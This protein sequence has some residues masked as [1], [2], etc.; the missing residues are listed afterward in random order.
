MKPKLFTSIILFLSAYSPLL[1]IFAVKDFN[2]ELNWFNHPIASS[3][4][5]LI[6]VS[7]IFILYTI[8]DEIKV[9]SMAV[10]IKAVNNRS[11]DVIN[12]TIP[13]LFCAFDIDLNQIADII[14]IVIFLIILFILT[15]SSK[16]IFINPILA[17]QGYAFYDVKYEFDSVE[18]DSVFISKEDLKKDEVYYVRSLSRFLY[19]TRKKKQ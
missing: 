10:K 11:L 2:F 13:Y 4:L 19:I 1:L 16:S 18:F 6:S 12:Y 9:G 8:I 3:S 7:S 15:L 14:T 5:L 17:L